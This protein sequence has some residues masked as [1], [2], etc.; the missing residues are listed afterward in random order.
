MKQETKQQTDN[1]TAQTN[2]QRPRNVYDENLYTVR[3][4]Y[5]AKSGNGVILNLSAKS[6]GGNWRN[7]RVYVPFES[8]YEDATIA[9]VV[10]NNGVEVA[11]VTVYRRH[12]FAVVSADSDLQ[13]CDDYGDI[14]F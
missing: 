5:P 1:Q 2:N 9:N 11:Q 8:D 13:S 3:E 7:V 4:W 6:K 12:E 14:P 10:K